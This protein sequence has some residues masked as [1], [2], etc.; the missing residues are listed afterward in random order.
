[1]TCLG[2]HLGPLVGGGIAVGPLNQVDALVN[3]LVHLAHGDY[4]LSLTFHAPTTVGALTA[5]TCRQDGQRLHTQIL[6]ELEVL[7]IAQTYTLVI[8][9]G[10]LKLATCFL[11][12]DSG[13]P[14]IGVPETIATAVNHATTR[15]SHELWMQVGQGL[16]QV[17]T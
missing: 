7:E 6:A 15:E 14:A 16:S 13:L 5:Y 4:I 12:A 11:G 17:F 9:P 1:M 3:P 10:V 8:T 2:T